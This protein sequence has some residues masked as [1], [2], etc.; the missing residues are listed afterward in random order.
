MYEIL[1]D[2]SEFFVNSPREKKFALLGIISPFVTYFSIWISISLSSWFSWQKNALSDLGHSV[3]SNVAPIFNFGLLLTGFLIILYA[4]T[5]FQRHAQYTTICLIAS[6]IVLQ[7][8][9][10]FDEV[11]GTLH[12]IMAVLFFVSIWITSIVNAI[13]KRS[14][15]ALMAFIV[16]IS[17]WVLYGLE[18]Y[19]SGVAVPEII[20]FGAVASLLQFSAV[21]IYLNKR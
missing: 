18:V 12:N 16:G 13:E 21:K 1:N 4:V 17:S 8:V 14:L 20:S 10:T 15:L 7:L 19:S 6:A 2:G 3:K 11:Y 9:A 5:V